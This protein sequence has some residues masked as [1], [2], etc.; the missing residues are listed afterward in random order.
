M[1]L[2]V[3]YSKINN[4]KGL[5]NNIEIIA[6]EWFF[7]KIGK[8]K[9]TLTGENLYTVYIE[10]SAPGKGVGRMLLA[11]INKVFTELSTAN[12]MTIRH[13]VNFLNE[14]AELKLKKYYVSLG[15]TKKEGLLMKEFKP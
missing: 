2:T 9:A 3:V 10:S 1:H 6:T 5:P 12:S 14:E 15:Y 13:I 8:A 7:R 11:K 4:R